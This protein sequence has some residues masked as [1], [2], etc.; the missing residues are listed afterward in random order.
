MTLI[1]ESTR[2][3]SSLRRDVTP[4]GIGNG[5]KDRLEEAVELHQQKGIHP[6][7]DSV[8]TLDQAKEALGC[9]AAGGRFGKGGVEVVW[10]LYGT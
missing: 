3:C 9:V 2:M 10:E 1:G 8:F 6:I 5:P 4:K 7:V